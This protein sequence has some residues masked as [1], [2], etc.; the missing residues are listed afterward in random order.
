MS[1]IQWR[2]STGL[3]GTFHTAMLGVYRT[4][5]NECDYRASRFLA[6]TK[7]HGG[8]KYA[9]RLLAMSGVSDGFKRLMEL[10]RLDLA[11]E[12]KVLLPIFRPLFTDNEI[13]I[14]Q[15]RLD[16]ARAT[17]RAGKVGK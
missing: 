14:A 5:F 3:D 10:D 12:T 15:R 17:I 11:M 13:A 16:Q 1:D 9:K 2:G 7:R 6:A 4:A 8:L